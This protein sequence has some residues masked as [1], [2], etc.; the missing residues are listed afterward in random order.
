MSEI[1]P[2]ISATKQA[3]QAIQT[4]QR[5]INELEQSAHEPIAVVGMACHFP[6][7]LDSPDAFWKA[8]VDGDDLIST[9]PTERWD[10]DAYYDPTPDMPG[11]MY[12]KFGGFL[13]DFDQFDAAF[14]GISPREAHSM[15]P[16]QRLLLQTVWEAFDSGGFDLNQLYGNRIGVYV[17]ISNFEYG[18]HL[19]WPQDKNN[20]TAYAGTGGSLGVAAGRISYTFGFTG[21]SMIIDTACSSS[22]VT[23]HLAI[24]ALRLGECDMAVSAGVNLIL[25]PE[26]HINFC[27]AHML[28]PDGHCKTFSKDADG[29]ARGEGVGSIL[30]KR[31]SDAERDGDTIYALLLGSAVNQDGPSGGLTVPNGPSQER[32]IQAALRNAGITPADVGYIEAHGTGTSLGDPIEISAL[33]RVFRDSRDKATNPLRTGSVK[34]NIGHLESAAGIAGL[35]K[36][37]LSTSKGIVPPHRNFAGPNPHIDWASFPGEIPLEPTSWDADRRIGGVSSFSFSGTNAHV[38]V[39]NYPQR[40]MVGLKGDDAIKP[41]GQILALSGKSSTHLAAVQH[42]T[43][44]AMRAGSVESW[45]DWCTSAA[46][47]RTHHSFRTTI[48]ANEVHDAISQL[49]SGLARH[50]V[51]KGSAPR[52]VFQFTG[53]GAQFAGMGREL[54]DHVEEFRNQID[55]CDAI[56]EPILG[57]SLISLLYPELDGNHEGL[58]HATRYTQPALFAFEYALARYLMSLGIEP[59]RMI[60]HSLGEYVAATIAGVFRLED[61]L[62]IVCERGRLMDEKCDTGSMLSVSASVA[63]ITPMLD[64]PEFVGRLSLASVNTPQQVVVAG[65]HASVAALEAVLNTLDI[66]NKKLQISHAFHSPLVDPMLAEF[67]RAFEGVSLSRPTIPVVSYVDGRAADAGEMATVDYWVGHIRRPVHYAATVEHILADKIDVIIEIGPKPILTALGKANTEGSHY[68]KSVTWLATQ[69]KQNTPWHQLLNVIAALYEMGLEQ[70]LKLL[71]T[72]T[73]RYPVDLPT[74]PFI[75]ERFWLAEQEQ[76]AKR[77]QRPGHPLLGELIDSPALPKGTHLFLQQLSPFELGFLTHHR[78]G[79]N[80]ILPAAAHTEILY[81]AAKRILGHGA[82]LFDIY[83]MKALELSESS[84]THIQTILRSD[85]TNGAQLEIYSR[86]D[87]DETWQL[88]TTATSKSEPSDTAKFINLDQIRAEHD[89]IHDVQSYYDASH[90]LGIEHGEQFRAI[91]SIRTAQDSIFGEL[92]LPTGM[93]R[94]QAS[95]FTLHPVLLDAAYQLASFA[96]RDTLVPYLPVGAEKVEV[97]GSL[98]KTVSCLCESSPSNQ[99]MIGGVYACDITLTDDQGMVLACIKNL[100]FQKTS[101]ALDGKAGRSQAD[102]FYG[103]E[104]DNRPLDGSSAPMLLSPDESKGL[105]QVALEA[106]VDTCGFYRQL[107]ENFDRLAEQAILRSLS[108]MGWKPI[109]GWRARVA[110]LGNELGIHADFLPLFRRCLEIVAESGHLS[111]DDHEL[112]VIKPIEANFDT[113]QSDLVATFPQAAAEIALLYRCLEGLTGVLQGV[114]DPIQLL[115]PDGDQAA[116]T[117]LYQ[118]SIGSRAIN[119]VLA[120]AV[121]DAV[122]ELPAYRKLRVL[123]IGSGTGGTT[124]RVLPVLPSANTEY[125]FTDISAHFTRTGAEQFGTTYPFVQFGTLDIEQNRADFDVDAFDI[126]IAANVLH[127]TRDIG[128]TLEHCYGRLAPG[129][130]IMLL[131]ASP[132]QRWLDMTFGMTDGW[133]RFEGHDKHRV[134]YPLLDA[135]SWKNRLQEASFEGAS[136]IG[137]DHP[138]VYG[139]LRQQVIVARKAKD[140][141]V[142]LDAKLYVTGLPGA[143]IGELAAALHQTA[144]PV[145]TNTVAQQLAQTS[146]PFEGKAH[147]VL[148]YPDP[149]KLTGSLQEAQ[150]AVFEP[151]INLVRSLSETPSILIPRLCVV[152]PGSIVDTANDTISPYWSLPGL[153]R[154]IRSEYPEFKATLVDSGTQDIR[155]IADIL[156][157]EMADDSSDDI[158]VYR[159]QKRSVQRLRRTEDLTANPNPLTLNREASYLITGG[160]GRMGILTAKYLAE[161]GAKTIL[162]MG[163]SVPNEVAMRELKE[164]F[165]LN[166]VNIIPVHGDVS[167]AE[168]ISELFNTTAYPPICGVVHAAGTLAD[169]TIATIEKHHLDE[170]MQSK[171]TG[172]LLLHEATIGRDLEFFIVY[173]SIGAV[174]GPIGQANY[175][176]ANAWMDQLIAYRVANGLPGLSIN[177][178]AWSGD[179]LAQR[180][181]AHSTTS[182][183][184]SIKQIDPKMGYASFGNLFGQRGQILAVPID[185]AKAME[186]LADKPLLEMFM[187]DNLGGSSQETSN[188]DWLAA[189]H[190]LPPNDQIDALILIVRG[191]TAKVLGSAEDR[192]DTTVGFFDMGMDSLTSVELRNALQT[193]TN[194][195]LPTT[196]IFKYPTIEALA[197]YLVGE[198]F[199]QNGGIGDAQTSE[200]QSS[201]SMS[202]KSAEAPKEVGTMSDDELSALIDDAFNDVLGGDS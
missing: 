108:E 2:T 58:I 168:V 41:N 167:D 172:T 49:E 61:A 184:A 121:A 105:T 137:E 91:Q 88:H 161:R 9:I 196:L 74:T 162:L 97:Y 133:W 100:Q 98:T 56:C 82:A 128:Q 73:R 19:I 190:L 52:I 192:I 113:S 23:T 94:A 200:G 50:S 174:F 175:A 201:A 138:V 182:V 11:K 115:F 96:L 15:D 104:W 29:Y 24:Q 122:K 186:Y 146:I 197:M 57:R 54:Y 17:G 141:H 114:V 31:L 33:S 199:G 20:I 160:F 81:T 53:Q 130:F 35:I 180:G 90:A 72:G 131:E 103:L 139:A 5:R 76:P 171:I 179:G 144:E 124:A 159:H 47:G 185:W 64:R 193:S 14:F 136:V 123:E 129:G 150:H 111:H 77:V 16:Q 70:P 36:T 195:S 46:L 42:A 154:T 92:E 152:A 189:I 110:D 68:E 65:D 120:A 39:S 87:G 40:Q 176:A 118:H 3:L 30:L 107:F 173:S 55:V 62:H 202:K 158:I 106:V 169:A 22:L 25:G 181:A 6:G 4:L 28:A 71:N 83:I 188:G 147:V 178:G 170:V 8:L 10:V 63:E 86:S 84:S 101:L 27:Q 75:T 93:L 149:S 194:L 140:A 51:K 69:R 116:A 85:G 45:V 126:I 38:V 145:S 198:L 7:D 163:R 34:T 89:Q 112:I 153:I 187:N 151:L 165:E 78:V 26:T 13:K 109:V 134:S 156:K 12:T 177:W 21:P 191:L 67:K 1:A 183:M 80:V 117:E 32:V 125:W 155:Y 127:A 166:G 135:V 119:E 99:G 148:L 142:Q 79:G 157:G 164:T 48:I 132:K 66:E 37:I 43:L 143:L 59:E 60:G 18:A 44:E 95:S 102:W